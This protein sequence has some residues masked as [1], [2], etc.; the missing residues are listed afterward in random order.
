MAKNLKLMKKQADENTPVIPDVVHWLQ[1]ETWPEILSCERVQKLFP[2]EL[3]E[4][5]QGHP[6]SKA[7]DIKGYRIWRSKE[8]EDYFA[9]SDPACEQILVIMDYRKVDFQVF[10]SQSLQKAMEERR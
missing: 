3:E 1:G 6:E 7:T 2:E 9:D 10:G 5:W 4:F 8:T